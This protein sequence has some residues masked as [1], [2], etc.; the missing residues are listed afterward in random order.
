L[1]TDPVP[2]RPGGVRRMKTIWKYVIECDSV[3]D[4]PFPIAVPAPAGAK[5]ISVGIQDGKVC[6]WAEVDPA[7]RPGNIRLWCVGTGFGAVPEGATFLGTVAQGR[8]VWHLYHQ[9]NL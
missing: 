4:A 2:G 6:V 7:S 8:F 9:P 5:P 3:L 1:N